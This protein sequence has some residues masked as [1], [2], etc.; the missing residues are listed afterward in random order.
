[1]AQ[2]EIKFRGKRVDNGE[3]V[4]GDLM[5][6]YVHHEGFKTIVQA[7]CVYYKVIPE[8]VG[9]FTGL[10]DKTGKEIYEGDRVKFIA[11][12]D[13]KKC[14]KSDA[15]GTI[16]WDDEDAGFYIFNDADWFPHVKFWFAEQ[17]EII[18]TIHDTPELLSK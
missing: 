9:Q 7:G 4:Y 14:N 5:Q 6:N 8:T 10:K 2:R 1:M 12:E 11:I 13:N 16:E 17:I 15:I 18:G 3:W